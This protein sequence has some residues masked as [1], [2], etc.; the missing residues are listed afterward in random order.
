MLVSSLILQALN[1]LFRFFVCERLQ[2]AIVSG[3]LQDNFCD[4]RSTRT[5]FEKWPERWFYSSVV[6]G[7]GGDPALF[8]SWNSLRQNA[9]IF[10]FHN[11]FRLA[12]FKEWFEHAIRFSLVTFSSKLLHLSLYVQL[13]LEHVLSKKYCYSE[14]ISFQYLGAFSQSTGH[15][16]PIWN[17]QQLAER[18]HSM[19][20]NLVDRRIRTPPGDHLG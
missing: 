11:M 7:K 18:N 4:N 13:E 14:P 15:S 19:N 6:A 16:V 1:S 2:R 20:C 12:F 8:L 9:S 10:E 5:R 3:V 17:S